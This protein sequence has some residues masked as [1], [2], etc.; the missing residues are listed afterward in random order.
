MNVDVKIKVATEEEKTI[1]DKAIPIL[2][3]YGFKIVRIEDLVLT[4]EM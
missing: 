2:D 4:S 1:L 3:K